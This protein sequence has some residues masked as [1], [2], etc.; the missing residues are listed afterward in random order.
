METHDFF[1]Y[2]LVILLTA[3][4]FAELATRLQ[5]PSVIGELFA[6]VVLGPSLLGWIEPVEAIKLMAEIGIILLLF[7][8]GLET[9]VKRLVHAGLKSLVVAITGF[10]LPLALG[11]ALGYWGF[12]L[13]LLVSLFIGGTITATSI[14]ITVRVLSDLKRQQAPEAQIVLGAAVLDDILGVVLLALLYEFSI[15]GGVSL[16]NASKVL[17]FVGAFFV[18]APIAAKLIS[19]II[20]QFDAISEIPGLL[21]TTIVT[22]VLFF[23]WLAHALGAPE[24]LGGF[25]AGLALSRRFFLPLGIALHTDESFAHRIEDQMK[26]IV[27]L[28]TPIFFVFVGLSLNLREIDWGSPFIWRFSLALLVA[29]IVGKLV[30]A[31]L[32]KETWASRCVVAMAMIPRGEV[33]L[34]FAELGRVSRIF[35]N[36]IYAGMV[37]VIALTTLLPPFIMKWF[38][39]RYGDHL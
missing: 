21:P 37:V 9:D 27:H 28:F 4:V 5:A 15:G 38:Y 8:V 20:K 2:L 33:G 23:A 32:I 24:L 11:F 35:S 19:L 36:E 25:A 16:L 7:E 22:L 39:G 10:V 12:G 26:P 18:L 17:V 3:R 6:G 30:G 31:F 13:S 14:G 29:A 34:I 1:L